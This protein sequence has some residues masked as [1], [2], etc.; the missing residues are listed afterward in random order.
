MGQGRENARGFLLNN[1]EIKEKLKVA[2]MEKVGLG[3]EEHKDAKEAKE[4]KKE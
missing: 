1:P 4:G 2:I 3:K